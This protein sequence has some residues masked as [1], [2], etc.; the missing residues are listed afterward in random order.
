MVTC[1]TKVEP[2][3]P[4]GNRTISIFVACCVVYMCILTCMYV[5]IFSYNMY[6]FF[7]LSFDDL[8]M[9]SLY[10]L[11]IDSAVFPVLHVP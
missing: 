8:I 5:V 11:Q 7:S 2:F 6:L 1:F 10:V 4:L 9:Y 3:R